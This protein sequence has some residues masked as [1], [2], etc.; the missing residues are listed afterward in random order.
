M[1]FGPAS[2]GD[3]FADVYDDW[4]ADVSDVAGTVARVARLAEVA[5]GGPVLELG[6]GTGRLALPMAAAGLEV[7][8][9]EA[10][11]AMVERLRAKPGGAPL[12]VAVGDMADVATVAPG[13]PYAVVLVAFNTFF[14]LATPAAQVRCLAGVAAVLAPGGALV[15]EA[16]VPADPPPL[17]GAL[18]VRSVEAGRVVLTASVTEPDGRTVTGSHVE[19]ADGS[20]PRLRPWRLRM[21][22]PAELDALAGRA[23]LVLAERHAGWR[24]EPF[25]DASGQ[26]VS[27]YREAAGRTPP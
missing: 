25:H 19:L 24:G 14:N 16:F 7:H 10:S 17:G 8:G 21:A 11:A 12:P 23:G 4:Y 5:G 15:V 1:T 20:R 18:A 27:V 2:Y 22:T 3:A 13:G 6:I 9:I 26:H